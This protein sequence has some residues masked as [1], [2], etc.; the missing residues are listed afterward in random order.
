MTEQILP[1]A[2]EIHRTSDGGIQFQNH[3]IPIDSTG[4]AIMAAQL[5]MP[6][7]GVWVT[8]RATGQTGRVT[9]WAGPSQAPTLASVNFGNT[10]GMYTAAELDT[11]DMRYAKPELRPAT[12]GETIATRILWTIGIG[13][14]LTLIGFA[15]VTIGLA[16]S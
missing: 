10:F 3:H 4:R 1:P 12:P 11:V 6:G 5:T 7:V 9:A 14:A 8:V 15:V 2:T 16:A 13:A